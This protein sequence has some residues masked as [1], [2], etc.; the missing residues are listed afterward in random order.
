MALPITAPP[1]PVVCCTEVTIAFNSSNPTLASFAEDPTRPIAST[2]SL[3]P[4]ANFVSTATNLLTEEVV[5]IIA[6]SNALTVAVKEL[7][8]LSALIPVNLTN[9][10]AS[11][12]LFNVSSVLRP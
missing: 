4:T 11:E 1:R 10:K 8:A 9:V 12:V 6:L 3:A 5:V 2:K 7:T